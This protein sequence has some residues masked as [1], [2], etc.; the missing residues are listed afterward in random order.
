MLY[1]SLSTL[2]RRKNFPKTC[3]VTIE[4]LCEENLGLP[5]YFNPLKN[6]MEVQVLLFFVYINVY[7]NKKIF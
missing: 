2:L 6:S 5:F 7:V 1:T 4:E 3:N